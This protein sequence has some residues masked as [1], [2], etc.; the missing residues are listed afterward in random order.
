MS[1]NDY[2]STAVSRKLIVLVSP[3]QHDKQQQHLVGILEFYV[4]GK[5]KERFK[6]DLLGLFWDCEL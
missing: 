2:R 4:L 5:L 6:C 1:Q 3:F